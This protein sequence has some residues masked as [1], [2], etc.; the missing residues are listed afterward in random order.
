MTEQPDSKI[1]EVKIGL[2]IEKSGNTLT[3]K[4]N[5]SIDIK[6]LNQ[7]CSDIKKLFNRQTINQND[8]KK[9]THKSLGKELC[10]ELLPEEIKRI[11]LSTKA[12]HLILKLDPQLLQLPWESLVLDNQTLGER[13]SVGRIIMTYQDAITHNV[14]DWG[15][16]P[17]K[18]QIVANPSGDLDEAT[19]EAELLCDDMDELKRNGL[20]ID[21]YL[22]TRVNVSDIEEHLDN[23][24]IFHFAGHADH[25]A[26]QPEECG[27]KLKDKFFTAIDVNK[28]DSSTKM[29][30]LVVSN[31]CNSAITDKWEFRKFNPQHIMSLPGSF[32]K[33]GVRHYVGT[34]WK[35]K[36][37]SGIIFSQSFYEA[38]FSGQPIGKCLQKA[39]KDMIEKNVSICWASYILYGNPRICYV[40]DN[41]PYL[42]YQE[43]SASH[44]NVITL[45]INVE[46]MESTRLR[47][48]QLKNY[49]NIAIHARWM[50]ALILAI[51]M[52][53]A[54][55]FWKA[56]ETPQII[57]ENCVK[58]YWEIEKKI[59][60][61]LEKI[62]ELREKRKNIPP[63]PQYVQQNSWTSKPIQ[64]AVTLSDVMLCCSGKRS[65]MIAYS[66]E[67]QIQKN[68]WMRRLGRMEPT[69][70]F[71]LVQNIYRSLNSSSQP[72]PS[73]IDYPD[74]M[75]RVELI[76]DE[77]TEYLV[78]HCLKMT[79][80]IERFQE[81]LQKGSIYKQGDR[82]TKKMIKWMQ[83]EF[84]LRATII[85]VSP[86]T[87]ELDIGD[88]HDIHEGQ[89]FET[90]LGQSL[91]AV[92]KVADYTCEA[93]LLDTKV[94]HKKGMRVHWVIKNK[95]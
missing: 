44:E 60:E 66:I 75:I 80:D 93:R 71:I 67:K 87:V 48:F 58:R 35:I 34:S 91:M 21:C 56:P 57:Y 25:K 68:L 15:K 40:K 20:N 23:S 50:I 64:I 42:Y 36:D 41:R 51:L 54:A 47:S 11:L 1:S 6:K 13:F 2:E 83:K 30:S 76:Y 55:H 5:H 52:L 77:N 90:I 94:E 16:D 33:K 95:E 10:N 32:I 7:K 63:V 85:K 59:D 89:K 81:K 45:S 4:R 43:Q 19:Q 9:K 3:Q 61:Y 39:R 62:Y 14:I 79:G 28:L 92:S 37:N 74:I 78:M 22:N 70:F 26:R 29:P 27:L 38:L 69:D 46:S 88:S 8:I 31:A 49:S 24:D 73:E 18:V 53:S 86:G 17:L 82:V 84:P 65:K 72:L 12:E